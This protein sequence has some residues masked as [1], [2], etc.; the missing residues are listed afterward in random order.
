MTTGIKLVALA[1]HDGW[2][3]IQ[4]DEDLFLLRPPYTVSGKIQC[5]EKELEEAVVKHG[6]RSVDCT[7]SNYAELIQF[8]KNEYIKANKKSSKAVPT[9]EELKDLL[10]YASEDV[11]IKFLDRAETDLIPGGKIEAAESLATKNCSVV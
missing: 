10:E 6:F 2:G 9:L 1:A 3:I 4:E 7:F 8:I 11:L 5:T